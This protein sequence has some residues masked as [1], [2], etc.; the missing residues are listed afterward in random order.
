[1]PPLVEVN[2][3]SKGNFHEVTKKHSSCFIH[4]RDPDGVRLGDGLWLE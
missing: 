4:F 1:M 3:S 2:L